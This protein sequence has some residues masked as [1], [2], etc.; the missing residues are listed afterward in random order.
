MVHS[1]TVAGL[2]ITQAGSSH[3]YYAAACMFSRIYLHSILLL[4]L[5]LLLYDHLVKRR[6]FDSVSTL[7]GR[8]VITPGRRFRRVFRSALY[9]SPLP[10]GRFLYENSKSDLT[11]NCTAE[12]TP[13][14]VRQ[15]QQVSARRQQVC[16][17]RF[18]IKSRAETRAR[19]II[20]CALAASS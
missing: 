20:A 17:G 13:H 19:S 6:I 15:R 14:R 16:A 9:L 3:Y 1:R 12:H 18:V 8:S 7:R 5:L 2:M 4:L 10:L 11:R